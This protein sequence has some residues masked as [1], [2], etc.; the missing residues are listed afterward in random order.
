MS[1]L[2]TSGLTL[3]AIFLQASAS[4]ATRSVK[5][6]GPTTAP[7]GPDPALASLSARQAK[8]QGLMTSG[9]YGHTSTGSSRSA[10]LQSSLASRLQARTASLG[11]TLY[12]LT[13]KERATPSGRSIPA[14]RAS[15]RPTSDKGSIGLEHGWATPRS[16]DGD[17][18]SRT[19]AGCESEIARKGRLDDLPSTATYLAGWPTPT[20]QDSASSGAYGYNGQNFMTLTDAG[21]MSGWG[22]PLAQQANGTPEAFLERKRKSME[23]GSQSMGVCLSDLNMQVQAWAGWPTPTALERNAS[24]DTLQKRRDF[25][26]ANA[27]QNTTPMYLNE[28]AQITADATLCEAMGYPVTPEGPAR[29]TVSGELLTGSSAGMES[30]GQLNPGHSRWLMGLPPEWDACGVTAMHS[31]PSKRRSSS[32]K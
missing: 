4:G 21:R 29:L 32:K 19:A 18:G 31:M 5:P 27:N 3:S 11:S 15:A 20:V 9:T 17:K 16:T 7:S 10:A 1:R 30:G 6:V 22:T 25:R 23:R 24:P 12:K 8:A 28:A 2:T 13:W 14:L 26:K